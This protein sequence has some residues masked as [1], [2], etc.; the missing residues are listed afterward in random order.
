MLAA[1][2]ESLRAFRRKLERRS[3]DLSKAT[4]LRI[5]GADTPAGTEESFVAARD[6]MLIVAAPGGPMAVDAHDTATPLAVTLK[7]ARPKL[8]HRFE[9]PDPLADPLLDQ[10]IKSA[11][12]QSYFV[13]AGDYIQIIDVDGRQCTDFQCFSARKLDKGKD[14]PLDVTTTRTLMGSSY[15]M[16]GL[17]SKYY[18]Q[19]MEP[20]VEVVQD[21]CGRHDAFALACAAK[22]YD[23]IGYPG[24]ANCSDNFNRALADKGVDAAR[25]LDGDQLLLQHRHR[26][27]GTGRLRRAVV[28]AGRLRAAAGADRHRLRLLGL[29]GRHHAGQ[30]LG[31]DRHPRSHLFGRRKILSSRSEAHDPRRRTR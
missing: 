16:P 2:D 19:D 31:P 11:T 24:H 10:R 29:P 6:G 20:L 1:G 15:P 23:D 3:I 17:H 30:W 22:Y 25:R 7:R 18:D 14:H 9:L 21:T 8:V 28:A 13:K 27:A 26:R 12:A 4:A 5:F